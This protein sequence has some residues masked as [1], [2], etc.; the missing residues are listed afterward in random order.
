MEIPNFSSFSGIKGNSTPQKVIPDKA[1]D[2][3]PRVNWFKNN[4]IVPLELAVVTIFL[5]SVI[6]YTVLCVIGNIMT[7]TITVMDFIE[8]ADKHWKGSLFILFVLLYRPVLLK[9]ENLKKIDWQNKCFEWA[10]RIKKK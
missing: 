2:D 5:L 8:H 7:P 9:L 3:H 1:K 10:T 4:V 6:L